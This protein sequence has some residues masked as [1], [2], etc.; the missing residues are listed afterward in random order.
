MVKSALRGTGWMP[1]SPARICDQRQCCTLGSEILFTPS[2]HVESS[3][4]SCKV[5]SLCFLSSCARIWEEKKN[6]IS[7][8][9]VL[10]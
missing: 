5:V 10:T 9:H 7:L 8:K 1:V 2:N 3:I 4:E 6:G